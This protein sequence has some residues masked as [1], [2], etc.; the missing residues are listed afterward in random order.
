MSE[1]A[2]PLTANQR[3]RRHRILEATRE[4]VTKH[5]YHGTIMRD[6]AAKAEVSATTLYNLYNTKDELLL[7]A[8]KERIAEATELAR[9]EAPEPGHRFLLA[10]VRHVAASTEATP[11]Y[12]TAISQALFRANSGDALVEVLLRE[13]RRRNRESLQ[14]MADRGELQADTDLD[15]LATHLVG[16]FWSTFLLWNKGLVP[17]SALAQTLLRNCLG[18]LIPNARGAVLS[19]L[20]QLYRDPDSAG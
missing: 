18:V 13:F 9:K 14:A 15:S 20:Q 16:A 8:L 7:E 5:G 19:E 12:V 10:H 11:A 17:L 2:R 6:V 3:E 1:P 4:L